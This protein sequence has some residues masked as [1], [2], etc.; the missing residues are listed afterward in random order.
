MHKVAESHHS[1][2]I[3]FFSLGGTVSVANSQ[4]NQ[5]TYLLRPEVQMEL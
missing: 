1:L 2:D 3:S 4:W 5:V